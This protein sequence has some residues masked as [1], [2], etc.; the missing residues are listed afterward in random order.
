[1]DQLSG[2]FAARRNEDIALDMMKF[3]AATT[4]YGKLGSPGAGFQGGTE[5]KAEDYAAHLLELYTR[6]LHTVNGKK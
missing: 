5:S 3:I 6:C 4:G 1:M 2:L